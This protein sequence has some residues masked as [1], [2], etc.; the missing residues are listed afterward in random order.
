MSHFGDSAHVELASLVR[1]VLLFCWELFLLLLYHTR[2]SDTHYGMKLFLEG[3]AHT[4]IVYG[5][6]EGCR[7]LL[8]KN[9][10][11]ETWVLHTILGSLPTNSQSP[12]L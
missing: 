5:R 1:F 4:H 9:N 6:Q 8:V 11:I 3:D 12:P 2:K 10:S 7:P